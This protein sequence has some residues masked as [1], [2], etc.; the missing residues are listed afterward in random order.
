MV[1]PTIAQN[2]VPIF[3]SV[4]DVKPS[5]EGGPI[6][7]SGFNYQDEIAVSFLLEMLEKQTIIK[8]HCESHDDILLV[9]D[10]NGTGNHSVEFVQVKAS[11]QD[12]LWSIADICL[13]KSGK[14]GT[15][16]FEISLARDK[17]SETS[18]FRLVTLRPVVSDLEFLTFPLNAPGRELDGVRFK[19]LKAELDKRFPKIK[20]PKGNGA[21]YWI[22]N[23]FWDQRHSEDAVKK[24]TLI[25]LIKLSIKEGVPLLPEQA[26]SLLDELRGKA[27]EAG[28]AKWEP[29]RDKKIFTRTALREWWEKRAQELIEGASAPSGGKLRTKMIDAGLPEEL[30]GLAIELRRDYSSATRTSHYMEPNLEEGLQRRVKSEVISLRARFVAGQIELDSAGFHALCLDRMDKL[31][32]ERPS[33]SADQSAFLKGCMYDIADRCLLRFERPSR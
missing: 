18:F 27:K 14:P 10:L 20:S 17:H 7:R 24:D 9:Y 33:G 13:R 16:I 31:N 6:A 21:S 30:V 8:V 23:G 12:K 25:R 4:D 26:E 29:N 28:D 5:E 1:N 19:A 32:D 3:L 2:K 15:S 11:E 22:E